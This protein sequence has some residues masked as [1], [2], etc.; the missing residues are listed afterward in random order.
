MEI[1][2]ESK[3]FPAEERY[4]LRSRFGEPHAESLPTSVKATAESDI[5]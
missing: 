3:K 4:S 1:F 2:Y 5:R